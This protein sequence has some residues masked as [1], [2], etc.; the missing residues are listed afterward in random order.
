LLLW[1]VA[2]A[3]VPVV[4]PTA[5]PTAAPVKRRILHTARRRRRRSGVQSPRYC[6]GSECQSSEDR[7]DNTQPN[8]FTTKA[9]LINWITSA[10]VGMVGLAMTG[11][12]G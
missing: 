8:R 9:S 7:H 5:P 3:T 6:R 12:F 1:V 10:A 2:A 11:Y 4:A